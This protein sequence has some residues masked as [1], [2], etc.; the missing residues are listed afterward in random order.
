MCK[1]IETIKAELHS[2]A[3]IKEY[4]YWSNLTQDERI[5][6]LEYRKTLVSLLGELRAN[7]TSDK[8]KSIS[9]PPRPSIFDRY[10]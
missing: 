1:E 8:V 5:E 3:Y 9:R 7:P 2:T 4:E 10:Q 6:V